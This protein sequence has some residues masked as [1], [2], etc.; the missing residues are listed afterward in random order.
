MRTYTQAEIEK[1]ARAFL[2][3]V[4]SLNGI[5]E[6]LVTDEEF[7]RIVQKEVRLTVKQIVETNGRVLPT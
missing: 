4:R 1:R 2:E 6:H 5:V 7:E 3:G